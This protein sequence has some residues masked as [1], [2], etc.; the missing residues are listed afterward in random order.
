[1]GR[2]DGNAFGAVNRGA[3]AHRNQTI[4]ALCPVKRGG[5][6]DCGF[7]GV[8][9]GLVKD[10]CGHVPQSFQ[11]PLQDTGGLDARIGHDQRAANADA[12]ALAAQQAQCATF[13]LDLG[14]VLNQSHGV[15]V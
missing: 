7:G 1:M 4:T 14:Q 15:A 13:K 10:G 12:L 11:S 3:A 5:R 2:R 9:R 6:P 8:G